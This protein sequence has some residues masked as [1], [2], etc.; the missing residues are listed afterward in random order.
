[1]CRARR[2]NAACRS[3][4]NACAPP[5]FL[6][7]TR[8]YDD[9][10]P[11]IETYRDC[12]RE[13]FDL[14]SLKRVIG[15]I[16]TGK[17]AIQFVQTEFPSPFTGNLL[18][19]FVASY[20]YDFNEVRLSQHAQALEVNRQ[21]LHEV[22]NAGPVPAIISP[23]LAENAENYWQYREPQRRARNAEDL[24]E[25]INALGDATTEELCE[26]CDEK[27]EEYLSELQQQGRITLFDFHHTGESQQR[28]VSAENKALYE[29]LF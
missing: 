29:E 20:M 27:L 25:I 16:Q 13:A 24:L 10:P 3:G 26:R 6:Q 12:L 9:F 18:Y 2:R 4:S 19:N 15:D 5:I 8:Q 1:M 21:L 17:I 7:A 23:E 14:E 28:W 22:L 11:I